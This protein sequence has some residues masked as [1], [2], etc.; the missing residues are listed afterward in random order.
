MQGDAVSQAHRSEGGFDL[1]QQVFDFA[2]GQL[3]EHAE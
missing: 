3:F 2:L 1:R